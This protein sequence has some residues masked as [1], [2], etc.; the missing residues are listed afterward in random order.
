MEQFIEQFVDLA[1]GFKLTVLV[2][3]IFANLV[4]G[5][6]VSI[7]TKTF[8]LK[9]LGNFLFSRV[10]PYV[11]SYFTVVIVAVVAPVWE[12]ALRVVWG[13]IIATLAGAILSNLKEMGV[14]LPESLAGNK[15]D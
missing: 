13:L 1:N 8:R 4:S 2:G 3:L 10:L 6:A 12:V 14:N 15:E 7:Y 9:A 11:L 5:I